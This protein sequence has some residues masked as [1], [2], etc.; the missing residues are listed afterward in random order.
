VSALQGRRTTQQEEDDAGGDRYEDDYWRR[1]SLRRGLTAVGT[2][3]LTGALLFAGATGAS[4]APSDSIVVGNGTWYVIATDANTT[5]NPYAQHHGEAQIGPVQH[6]R[7]ELR[8]GNDR[9]IVVTEGSCKTVDPD[10]TVWGPLRASEGGTVT[11]YGA[12]WDED[13]N[14]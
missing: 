4:A 12:S 6:G 7:Q 8:L 11:C 1:G 2:L 13:E 3:A 5:G 14:W 10:G 9:A